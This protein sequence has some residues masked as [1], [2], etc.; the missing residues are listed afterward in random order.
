MVPIAWGCLPRS[1]MLFKAAV[2]GAFVP[3]AKLTGRK[4]LAAGDR[5]ASTA[6]F[7][8]CGP[9]ISSVQLRWTNEISEQQV[10]GILR[11]QRQN[12]IIFDVLTDYG[13]TRK[14]NTNQTLRRGHFYFGK[15]RTF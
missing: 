15:K 2:E 4:P 8:G 13:T 10:V 1:Q 12:G 14:T 11:V 9:A 7:A 6:S 3:A 5:R